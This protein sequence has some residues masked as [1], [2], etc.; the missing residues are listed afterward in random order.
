MER[1]TEFAICEELDANMLTQA[2]LI[3]HELVWQFAQCENRAE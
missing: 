2:L 3:Q 1:H